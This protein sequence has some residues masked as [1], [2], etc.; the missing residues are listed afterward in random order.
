MIIHELCVTR[1]RYSVL[2]YV[3]VYTLQAM[4]L[5]DMSEGFSSLE[6]GVGRVKCPVLVS[7]SPSLHIAII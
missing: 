4:D 1:N 2:V 7:F 3:H 6:E 5:F